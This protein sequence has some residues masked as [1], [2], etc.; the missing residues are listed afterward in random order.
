[1]SFV[2][3]EVTE[4]TAKWCEP[5][6]TCRWRSVTQAQVRTGWKS[7]GFGTGVTLNPAIIP[8]TQKEAPCP[9]LI[10][11]GAR[12]QV[13]WLVWESQCKQRAGGGTVGG[14][15]GAG[16][17]W[18]PSG[19]NAEL[20][21]PRP[22]PPTLNVPTMCNPRRRT[23]GLM[24]GTLVSR[25]LTPSPR[26]LLYWSPPEKARQFAQVLLTQWQIQ[27]LHHLPFSKPL[28]LTASHPLSHKL[29]CSKNR[30]RSHYQLYTLEGELLILA[31]H[32]S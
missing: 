32:I 2:N 25:R 26:H 31:I 13:W 5:L 30:T 1:M 6:N 9:R 19:A 21:A 28:L 23:G 29:L 14:L 24:E 10:A 12:Q 27:D 22:Q 11:V 17:A 16:E 20:G 8:L 3:P 4:K 15:E 7:C 18:D